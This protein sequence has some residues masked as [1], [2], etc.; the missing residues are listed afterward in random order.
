MRIIRKEIRK[1]L[2]L[3]LIVIL[4]LFSVIYVTQIPYIS[5]DWWNHSASPYEVPLHKELIG[6]YGAT[7]S[8]DE[9]D[10]FMSFRQGLID[11]LMEYVLHDEI[12]QKYDIDTYEK[13]EEQK[14][15]T[16]LGEAHQT[17]LGQE[18]SR[19]TFDD[20]ITSPLNFKI[21]KLDSLVGAK[22]SGHIF[23]NKEES[24]NKIQSSDYYKSMSESARNRIVQIW[25]GKEL[26]LLHGAVTE[27]VKD[28]FVRMAILAVIWCF[29][30][31]LPY[32]IT[33]RLKNVREIQLTTRTGRKIF[34]KQAVVCAFT[35]IVTGI[36]VSAV[37]G[38]MLWRK[39][40]FDFIHCPINIMMIWYWVDLT[41]GQFLLLYACELIMTSVA[42]SLFAYL[43]G[44][45]SA[46][47]VVGLG[48]SIPVTV[49]LCM[50]V[51]IIMIMPFE[52][53]IQKTVSFLLICVPLLI[54]PII[55]TLLICMMLRHDK[56]RDIL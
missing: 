1:V 19:L 46:N 55:G 34:G 23:S 6:R 39:G 42:A 25:T 47:Y 44:R 24:E 28:D 9:W 26:S 49:A 7:I 45:I 32:Q 33:E 18:F 14:E 30:L 3:R 11:E 29:V 16:A 36:L 40:A 56:V 48:I 35:G 22:E 54:I 17:E 51:N 50:A 15:I 4:L 10:D 37:Y 13:Y 8:L 41:Y 38:F 2:N 53:H 52:L 21:Q 27:N 20:P 31:I 12:M 43:I 5:L